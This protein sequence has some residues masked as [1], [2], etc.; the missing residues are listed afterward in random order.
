MQP[1]GDNYSDS[2]GEN[3]AEMVERG[4]PAGGGADGPYYPRWVCPVAAAT[5]HKPPASVLP[6]PPG[7]VALVVTWTA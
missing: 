1:S 6:V 7:L 4:R 3:I 5:L 2:R